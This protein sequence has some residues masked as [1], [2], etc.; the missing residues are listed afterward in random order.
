MWGSISIL[1]LNWD[2][3]YCP[4]LSLKTSDYG[5]KFSKVVAATQ[6]LSLFQCPL[7]QRGKSTKVFI[8][9]WTCSILLYILRFRAFLSFFIIFTHS[10]SRHVIQRIMKCSGFLSTWYSWNENKGAEE[11]YLF[12]HMFKSSWRKVKH[13]YVI[14]ISSLLLQLMKRNRHF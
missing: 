4:F 5:Y 9:F 8:T 12:F 1:C 7:L 11:C 3:V 2:K 10:I 6:S 14:L 13:L